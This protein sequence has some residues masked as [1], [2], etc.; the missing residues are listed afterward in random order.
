[1]RTL[2][3]LDIDREIVELSGKE[4]PKALFIPTASSDS[5][6]YWEAFD[7]AYRGELGCDTD[8]LYML[9][10]RPPQTRLEDAVLSADVIYVGGGNTLKMMRRW[11]LLGVDKLLETAYASGTVLAG[12][13]AGCICWFNYGHS[14]SM[15]F[16]TEDDDWSYIRV[17]GM[18]FINAFGCPHYNGETR[19]Q[20]FQAMMRR[21]SG[22]GIGIEDCCALEVIDGSYRIITSREDAAAYRI[23][24]SRGSLRVDKIPQSRAFAPLADLLH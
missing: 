24:R 23:E 14:D 9:G 15:S 21:H 10:K 12:L 4:R 13:S 5:V 16:Y 8:V 17:K 3:T 18:G 20:D 7:R 22:V 6:E 11:R 2:Q 1:M 19:E